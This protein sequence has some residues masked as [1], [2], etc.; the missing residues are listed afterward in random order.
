MIGETSRFF[1]KGEDQDHITKMRN[2]GL[3][4]KLKKLKLQNNSKIKNPI[5]PPNTPVTMPNRGKIIRRIYIPL[6]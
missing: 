3:K 1:K 6:T 4:K 2:S 5:P